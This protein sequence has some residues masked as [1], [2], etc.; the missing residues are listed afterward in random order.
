MIDNHAFPWF[1]STGNEMSMCPKGQ[2]ESSLIIHQVL[3][4]KKIDVEIL[5]IFRIRVFC[6]ILVAGDPQTLKS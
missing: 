4:E 5:I 2:Q 6:S 1:E 3:P